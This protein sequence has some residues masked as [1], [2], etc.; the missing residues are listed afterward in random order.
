MVRTH[1]NVLTKFIQADCAFYMLLDVAAGVLNNF[2]LRIGQPGLTRAAALACAKTRLLRFLR[3]CK[4]HDVL[5]LWPPRR[6]RWLAI[7]PCSTHRDEK[8][9]VRAAIS[10]HER[11][12]VLLFNITF[13]VI[14]YIVHFAFLL[15]FQ[16]FVVV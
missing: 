13:N 12:P 15:I 11:L 3:R 6:A 2:R 7:D 5:A 1:I 14:F 16:N 4:K 9:A 10:L 8:R